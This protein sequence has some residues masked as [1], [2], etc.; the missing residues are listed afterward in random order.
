MKNLNNFL[1][2]ILYVAFAFQ[3]L[4]TPFINEQCIGCGKRVDELNLA[5]PLRRMSII[6]WSMDHSLDLHCNGLCP[7]IYVQRNEAKA[8]L[9]AQGHK[10]N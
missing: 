5:K 8:W 1:I 2:A 9:A 7:T 6:E 3:I 4:S 10:C